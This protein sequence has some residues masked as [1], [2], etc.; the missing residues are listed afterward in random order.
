MT[1]K[2]EDSTELGRIAA[3]AYLAEVDAQPTL[4]KIARAA[5]KLPELRSAL[6][7]VDLR[8]ACLSSCTFDPIKSALE[9]QGLRAGF[10][11]DVYVGPF[12]QFEQEL[13]DAASGL[14]RF[15]PEAVI[16]AI[17][18]QDVCPALYEAFNG[19]TS[20]QAVE[21]VDDWIA[22]LR[23]ALQS[24]RQR[25]SAHVLIQNYEQPPVLS[26]GPADGQSDPSQAATIAR[27]N[28]RLA[29]LAASL[30]NVRVLDY[31]ALV[32]R[33]GRLNWQDA[34]TALYGR[35]A[36]SPQNYWPV[37][38][39]YVRHLRPLYGLTKKV[40]VLDADNTLWGGVVGDVGVDGIALGHDYP[41]SAYVA[42]QKR[43]LELH[44]RGIVLCLASK[45]EPSYIDEVLGNHPDMVLRSEH[46]SAVRVNWDPKPA[47]LR[48]MAEDLNLGIDSFV[49]IDDSAVECELMRQALP[50]VLTVHLPAEPALYAG[51]VDALDC[52]DQW[53]ISEEDRRRGKLYKAEVGRRELAQTAVDMP[54]FYRQLQMRLTIFVDHPAHVARAAQM[55]QRTNQFNMHTIRCSEDD[56]RQFMAATDASVL[57][58]AL[59]DRFGDNGV[60]GLAV[61][62]RMPGEW[63]LHILLMSC[64]IL[65]RTVEQAFVAWLGKRAKAAGIQRLVAEFVPT[66]KNKPFA[67]FYT[68]VGFREEQRTQAAELDRSPSIWALDLNK[69][70]T[71]M[72]DWLD[73]RVVE[74]GT[75]TA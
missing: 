23:S 50:E 42:L 13:I 12:G 66:V 49:F 38:G 73:V 53:A 26:L 7:R 16:L 40:I 70:D 36:V 39:F 25:S 19:L 18:L 28:Q 14:S 59:A 75:E 72:P 43:L 37:A 74:P 10:G 30:A 52:F 29:E 46:F 54:T 33:H 65:G 48:R 9:L 71:M 45:N 3:N 58:L 64:R 4:L 56:I 47:N 21:L 62:R 11:L 2:P 22:R 24:F 8:L 27:A 51:I 60:V 63:R 57:T 41:G 5:V 6:A 15:A 61:V 55:T 20:S 67:G 34:R 1:S 68:D 17:R 44:H 32:A 31:D 35:I 69:A